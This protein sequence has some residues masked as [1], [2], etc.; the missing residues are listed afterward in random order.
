[1]TLPETSADIFAAETRPIDWRQAQAALW[2]ARMELG[3]R[4]WAY[5][6]GQDRSFLRFKL[7]M[8]HSTC[9]AEITV[10]GADLY[11]IVVFKV[12]HKDLMP[13]VTEQFRLTNLYG[14]K[15][16]SALTAAWIAHCGKKGW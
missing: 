16:A 10:N 14:D 11:D 7:G 2:P 1:M 8:A 3:L 4:D 6:E 9:M 15:V 5:S 12:K 13:V